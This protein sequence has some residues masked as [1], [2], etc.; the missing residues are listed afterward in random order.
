MFISVDILDEH[1][2]NSCN[3]LYGCTCSSKNKKAERDYVAI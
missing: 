3:M 2:L 1:F